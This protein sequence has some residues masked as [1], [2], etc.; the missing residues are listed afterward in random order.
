MAKNTNLKR[1]PTKYIRDG[2]KANYVKKDYCE[3]CDTNEDIELHH[4]HSVSYLLEKYAKEQGISLSSEESVLAMREAFYEAHWHEL[5]EDTVSLCNHHHVTLHK[6]YGQKP[7][8]HTA[9]KQR[10]WVKKQYD[11]QHG[12]VEEAQEALSSAPSSGSLLRFLV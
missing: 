2:V 1:D 9:N 12:I 11:K 7:L 5:V 8:L 10:V 6:I 4:Y 3:I